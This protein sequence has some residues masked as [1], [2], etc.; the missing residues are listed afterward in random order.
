MTCGQ[1]FSHLRCLIFLDYPI[2][3]VTYLLVGQQISLFKVKAV[4]EKKGGNIE[5]FALLKLRQFITS[6]FSEEFFLN[7]QKIKDGTLVLELE[8]KKSRRGGEPKEEPK[9]RMY[10]S[11]FFSFWSNSPL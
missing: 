5:V 8:P 7:V 1:I 6:F 10:P 2:E 11:F 3:K 9:K 4:I